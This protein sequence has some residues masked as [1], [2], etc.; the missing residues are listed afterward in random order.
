[1]NF[2]KIDTLIW[3][4]YFHTMEI[5]D[6]YNQISTEFDK[7]RFSVWTGVRRFLDSLPPNSFNGEIGCGNGKNMLYRKDVVFEGVDISSEFVKICEKKGLSVKEDNILQLSIA[8]NSFDNTLCIAVIHHLQTTQERQTAI[9]ELFRITKPNGKILIFVWAFEQPEDAKR[10]FYTK[11]EWVPFKTADGKV[12]DRFYHMYE[13]GELE[14]EIV[15]A[16]DT[17]KFDFTILESYWEHGNWAVV[18]QKKESP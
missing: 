1:M 4:S 9:R 5:K 15:S 13:K 10:K 6:V 8:T 7:S 11:D 18:L 14:Q 12:F 3:H 17:S 16:K 2:D